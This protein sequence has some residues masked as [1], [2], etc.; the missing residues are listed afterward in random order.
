MN[1]EGGCVLCGSVAYAY[2]YVMRF[3]VGC[4]LWG[5]VADA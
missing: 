4:V 3:E 1:F 5:R 2:E